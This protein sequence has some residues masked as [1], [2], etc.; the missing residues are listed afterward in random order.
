MHK[1]NVG[2]RIVPTDKN[3]LEV[4]YTIKAIGELLDDNDQ[5]AWVTSEGGNTFGTIINLKFMEPYFEPGFYQWRG[6]SGNDDRGPVKWYDTKP[7]SAD[8]YVLVDVIP[9][10]KE[11][12]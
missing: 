10:E 1:F 8:H 6:W 2:D 11:E 4:I 9:R 5:G 7:S 12:D 3:N